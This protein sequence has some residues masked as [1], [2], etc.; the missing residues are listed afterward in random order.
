MSLDMYAFITSQNIPPVDFKDPQDS[1]EL[2]YWRKHP[3]P[4]GWMEQLYRKKGGRKN[5]GRPDLRDFPPQRK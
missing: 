4:H 5:G 3:N 1:E 2:Y